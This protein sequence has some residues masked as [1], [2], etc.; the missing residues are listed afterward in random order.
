VRRSSHKDLLQAAR[1]PG[2]R[3]ARTELATFKRFKTSQEIRPSVLP[4]YSGP[5]VENVRSQS[6]PLRQMSLISLSF[7]DF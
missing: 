6:P 5:Q 1:G 7:M 2:E 3:A 4:D